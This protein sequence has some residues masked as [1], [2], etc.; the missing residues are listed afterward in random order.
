MLP[1]AGGL[2]DQDEGDVK[3]LVCIYDHLEEWREIELKKVGSSTDEQQ[4]QPARPRG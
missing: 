3:R 2:L 1:K 4:P